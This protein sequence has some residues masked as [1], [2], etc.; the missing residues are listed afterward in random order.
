MNEKKCTICNE[1]KVLELYDLS[2]IGKYG[3]RSWC[4]ACCKEWRF[5]NKEATAEQNKL[6]IAANPDKVDRI[7]RR[8][9]LKMYS[10]L[11]L[12][13]YEQ[14]ARDQKDLCAICHQPEK[15]TCYR[16]C[17]DHN[18]TTQKVRGLLCRNCNAGLGQ[19]KDN[20]EIMKS[21]VNYLEIR[22]L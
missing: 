15:E 11:T 2:K 5:I 16:L 10:G 14:M 1:V 12:E 13:D 4:K 18:H 19:F 22:D 7:K 8:Y 9:K 6:W 3:R 21:A 17:I 20:L